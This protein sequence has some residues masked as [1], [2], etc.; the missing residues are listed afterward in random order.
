MCS[1]FRSAQA[2][3][4][5]K[6]DLPIGSTD[7]DASSGGVDGRAVTGGLCVSGATLSR[8]HRQSRAVCG[9]TEHR[10]GCT[11]PPPE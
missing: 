6:L 9:G 7:I 10:R 5:P 1:P 2:R 4:V 8:S 3:G 11:H